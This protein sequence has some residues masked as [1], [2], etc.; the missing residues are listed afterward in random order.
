MD[1]VSQVS[2]A[3]EK[4][5][6]THGRLAFIGTHG[7]LTGSSPGRLNPQVLGL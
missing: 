2:P 4:V 3:H 7:R 1:I 5:A 6:L